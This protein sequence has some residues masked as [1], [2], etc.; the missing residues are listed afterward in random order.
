MCESRAV[1]TAT[2]ALHRLSSYEPGRDWDAPIDDPRILQDLVT[3]DIERLPWFYKRYQELLPRVELPR[4]L[5]ATTASTIAVLAG[6]ADIATAEFDSGNPREDGISPSVISCLSQPTPYVSRQS[7]G[8]DSG[9][10]SRGRSSRAWLRLS[11]TA[12]PGE[13]RE[14]LCRCESGRPYAASDEE[15]RCLGGRR[16]RRA[17]GPDPLGTPALR[18]PDHEQARASGGLK[19]AAVAGRDEHGLGDDSDELLHEQ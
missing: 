2:Q 5:P 16:D 3:N 4:E 7:I 18:Q 9:T 1:E 17:N 15:D 19:D 6:T 13:S 10:R 14:C 11:R 8:L 12:R